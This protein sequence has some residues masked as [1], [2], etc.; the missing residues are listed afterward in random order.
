VAAVGAGA[1]AG[2]VITTSRSTATIILIATRTLVA[3]TGLPNYLLAV[4]PEEWVVQEVLA[5]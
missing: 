1:A 4:V 5:V 2:A 3:A